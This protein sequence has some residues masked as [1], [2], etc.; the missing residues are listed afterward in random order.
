MGG[1]SLVKRAFQDNQSDFIF[2][3]WTPLVILIDFLLFA[4]V[5]LFLSYSLGSLYPTL[6]MVED[7]NPP[8][9]EPVSLHEDA[10]SLAEDN[11]AAPTGQ[12]TSKPVTSSLR[13][14][15]RLLVS[16]SGFSS[17]FRGLIPAFFLAVSRTTLTAIIAAVPLVPQFVGTLLASLLLASISA[18]WVHAVITPPTKRSFWSRRPPLRKAF[19]ATC[20]PIFFHWIALTL[21]AYTPF[22]L[23]SAFHLPI[24]NP[25]N[26]GAVP[27]YNGS[28]GWKGTVITVVELAIQFLLVVPTEVALV[29][30]QASLLPPDEDTIIPFDRSFQGKV[31][32]VVVGG[33]GFVT[34]RD[35][36]ATFPRA[37]WVRLY[38]LYAKVFAVTVLSYL[39]MAAIIVPELFLLISKNPNKQTPKNVWGN[40]GWT[41][42]ENKAPTFRASAT[43]KPYGQH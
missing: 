31:E 16:V 41:V 6:A 23:A 25:S 37:S 15:R 35:A 2:S 3:K 38:I 28:M 21:A 5:F 12:H 34:V 30:V 20:F 29:R 4:P 17:H 13:A 24:W 26:P 27:S 43:F 18:V 33:K 14:T 36:L 8:A 11:P 9:Y 42:H 39:L 7:P 22:L 10:A 19:E 32:P 40:S 1:A